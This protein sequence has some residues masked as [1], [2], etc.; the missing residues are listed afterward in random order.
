MKLLIF[1]FSL[2]LLCGCYQD[3]IHISE[4]Y[5][6]GLYGRDSTDI[7][8]YK[9]ISAWKP[10]AGLSAFPDGGTPK[11]LYKNVSFYRYDR[12]RV[13]LN[14]VFDF[15]DLPFNK[16][17]W[18]TSITRNDS[19]ITFAIRPVSGWEKEITRDSTF[20]KYRQQF[21]GFFGYHLYCNST[22][23]FSKPYV[24]SPKNKKDLS[25]SQIKK[26]TGNISYKQWGID[27]SELDPKGKSGFIQDLITLQ[28]NRNYRKAVV[29]QIVSKLNA[30]EIKVI[31]EKM[32]A[33]RDQ[34]SGLEQTEYEITA[35]KTIAAL[36]KL[37]RKPDD[38]DN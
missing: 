13:E 11:L 18:L 34:L 33:Y 8:F 25:A 22:N 5:T 21:G 7:F 6:G 20:K 14:K 38:M 15:D 17:R 36:K 29:E 32:N 19:I 30:D 3:S 2:F 9:Y 1:V 10:A 24:I 27:L 12:Q 16:S 35:E 31:I 4:D 28:G 37:L 23:H 26:I